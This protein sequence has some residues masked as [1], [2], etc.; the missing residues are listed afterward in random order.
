MNVDP[1]RLKIALID[2]GVNYTLREFQS[3]I[4]LDQSGK[5]IG[6]DF[7]EQDSWP[8]DSDPRK[9]PF[10]PRSHGSTVFSVL[11][12]ETPDTTVAILGFQRKICADLLIF[13]CM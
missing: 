7:W 4:A 2:T 9:T 12:N 8:Y 5:I 13:C 11:A 1:G 10:F 6:Y 3:N